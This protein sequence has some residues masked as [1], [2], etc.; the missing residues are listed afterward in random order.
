MVR[1]S[2]TTGLLISL[3]MLG[4]V[5]LSPR[6]NFSQAAS[7]DVDSLQIINFLMDGEPSQHAAL[8]IDFSDVAEDRI[9]FFNVYLDLDADGDFSAKEWLVENKLVTVLADD[10][11]PL[12]K[13]F[14]FSLEKFKTGPKNET[15]LVR[16]G[17]SDDPLHHGD[18]KKFNWT[19]TDGTWVQWDFGPAVKPHPD[20]VTGWGGVTGIVSAA[21][22]QTSDAGIK[23]TQKK[24]TKGTIDSTDYT[25]M[26]D[27]NQKK[28]ECVP[29]ATANSIWWLAKKNGYQ[30]IIDAGQDKII[31]DL[32]TATQWTADGVSWWNFIPGKEEFISSYGLPLEVHEVEKDY[33]KI[34]AEINKGQDIEVI[35]DFV[36][37]GKVVAS[38]AATIAGARSF[39]T[40]KGKRTIENVVLHDPAT[41]STEDTYE[42][43]GTKKYKRKNKDGV[44]VENEG[45]QVLGYPKWNG[46]EAVIGMVVAESPRQGGGGLPPD[47]EPPR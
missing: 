37:D 25:G 5:F 33:D 24:T 22:A 28:N 16:Y 43:K 42:V 10:P 3:G 21:H 41:K 4:A 31:N 11:D 18:R 30:N 38:H 34:L 19:Q 14:S 8:E 47:N 2:V 36:K 9:F 27:I 13:S 12:T 29:T 40:N 46:G 35:I 39:T 7:G 17:L 32:K 26:P 45:W 1:R 20:F 23:N 15:T 44:E 6:L